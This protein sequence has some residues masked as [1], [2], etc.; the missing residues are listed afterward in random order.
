VVATA[1]LD[2]LLHHS[3]VVTIRGDS[4]RLCTAARS[5]RHEM[6]IKGAVLR[7]AKGSIPDVAWHMLGTSRFS[8]EGN[9]RKMTTSRET[10]KTARPYPTM[11]PGL[12]A[13]I[14]RVGSSGLTGTRSDD[15]GAPLVASLR[16]VAAEHWLDI[17]VSLRGDADEL[18]GRKVIWLSAMLVQGVSRAQRHSRIA[19]D[20]RQSIHAHP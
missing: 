18:A 15:V 7:D 20:G 10:A 6:I 1:I 5:W 17:P 11:W 2:R 13:S 19:L 8:A 9:D 4:Y 12:Q 3:H 16:L 14:R